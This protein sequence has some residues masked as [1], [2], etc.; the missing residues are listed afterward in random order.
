MGTPVIVTG[1]SPELVNVTVWAALVL[2]NG[3]AAK[4]SEAGETVARMAA[5]VPLRLADT[6]VPVKLPATTRDP[7]LLPRAV[8]VKVTFTVQLAFAA[9]DAPQLFVWL[10]SL[11]AGRLLMAVME[12]AVA[13]GLVTVTLWAALAV[14]IACDAKVS[15]VGE[16]KGA[17]KNPVPERLTGPTDVVLVLMLREPLREPLAVGVK[18]TDIVQLAFVT[19][20]VVQLLVWAKSPVTVKL[21]TESVRS[22][23]FVK[24]TIWAALL[25]LTACEPKLNVAGE[26]LPWGACPVPETVTPGATGSE[27]LSC[28]RM[29]V[30]DPRA[31]GAKTTLIVQLAPAASEEPQLLV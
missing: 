20:G 5:P 1:R 25:V 30:H 31:E 18:V 14:P 10:K 6:V 23:E 28:E 21:K 26:T 3:V 12:I 17:G 29:A 16:S 11:F 9:N 27:L 2:F 4:L 15:E 13:P 22:P 8:G 19:R 24:V 7:V